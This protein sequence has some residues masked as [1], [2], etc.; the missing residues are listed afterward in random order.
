MKKMKYSKKKALSLV[1]SVIMLTSMISMNIFAEEVVTEEI[2]T[3]KT[4]EV[5]T[6]VEEEPLDKVESG[7][8]EEPLDK[9]EA[10]SAE[11]VPLTMTSENIAIDNAHFPDA[12]FQAYIT[13]H[14][15]S[16]KDHQLSVDEITQA[17][18]INFDWDDTVTSVQGVEYFVNL[19][20][21]D[22]SGTGISS[23]D[24]SRNTMLK[25]LECSYV[26]A[27]SMLDVSNNRSLEILYCY[28]TNI[29]KLD[30]S[31]NTALV[32][33]DCNNTQITE[34]DVSNNKELFA[35]NCE[36]TFVENLD[37]SNNP[38]LYEVYITNAP[39]A[40]M[41]YSKNPELVHIRI[42]G[43]K[44]TELDVSNNLKLA[45]LYCNNTR[46]T[47]LNLSNNLQ[48]YELFCYNSDI[49][50]LDLSKFTNLHT[51]ECYN[52]NISE[53]DVSN[54]INLVGLDCSNT[55]V[56]KLDVGKNTKLQRLEFGNT[57]IGT[58]DLSNNVIL[59][60][61]NCSNTNLSKLDFSHLQNLEELYCKNAKIKSLNLSNAK[62]LYSIDCAD[63][64][65]TELNLSNVSDLWHQKNISPQKRNVYF[66]EQGTSVTFDLK[67]VVSDL[68]KVTLVDGP[69]YTFD[70]ASGIITLA[71]PEVTVVNYLYDHGYTN[72]EV[73]PLEVSLTIQKEYQM[74]S[75]KDQMIKEDQDITF[76][77]DADFKSFEKV[78]VD[79]VEI[80]PDN[81][82]AS[83]GST[84]IT[85][86]KEFVKTLS[87]GAHTIS[88]VSKD[89]IAQASFTISR[90]AGADVQVDHVNKVTAISKNTNQ[91][92][93]PKTGD[94]NS[95]I[96]W[97]SVLII[98]LSGVAFGKKIFR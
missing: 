79:E 89:G 64:Q 40:N 11:A 22:C 42:S 4:E 51:V 69:G 45:A 13:E 2:P 91:N 94:S 72:G 36:D 60:K 71:N 15:D 74:L 62:Q 88:I 75:G 50:K 59:K 61:L 80:S 31:N 23:L 41:D 83:E 55:K 27:L 28:E 90:R 82:I 12:V 24:V 32:R 10:A 29:D 26:K 56:T 30:V 97:L 17:K 65:M 78:L 1:L 37:I 70:K 87:E 3:E 77:S 98:A 14:F 58:I 54:N 63:N 43:T 92:Q 20:K 18:E 52:T 9:V 86:K 68:T 33:L 73:A 6:V 76:R 35:L 25:S 5:T 53:L 84:I 48:L 34:L 39:I 96:L 8:V 16:N 93:S 19:E 47:E 21:L 44:M 85:L 67:T 7:M 57:A 46:I 95:A 49:M 66:Q 81:Y 38:K